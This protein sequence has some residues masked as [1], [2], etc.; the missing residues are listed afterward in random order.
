[1]KFLY[2]IQGEAELV[3]RYYHLQD[4]VHSRA[5]YLTYDKEL[6]GALYRPNTTWAEGRN[7]LLE[8][9]LEFSNVEYFIFLDDDIEISKGNWDEFEA[10]LQKYRPAIGVPV[11]PKTQFTPIKEN[12]KTWDIQAF[13]IHD[14]QFMAVHKDVI[15]DK[16]LFPY[17]S[18][19][20]DL[21]WWAACEIQQILIHT[22]YYR[23][24]MQCNLV[25]IKNLVH[26]R[27]DTKDKSYKEKI[28]T[29]LQGQLLI[30]F[31]DIWYYWD[32]WAGAEKGFQLDELF[33]DR[34]QHKRSY[35][36]KLKDIII[37]TKLFKQK[38][39][40]IK[41]AKYRLSNYYKKR[42]FNPDGEIHSQISK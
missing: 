30:P 34:I 42:V 6:A 41:P 27:H 3:K 14:E 24:A 32:D 29:W 12:G 18:K 11:V 20:D 22:F 9:A 37:T 4:R 13:K 38:S 15:A 35:E 1:L 23:Y 40:K 36:E 5:I 33:H 28:R 25:E 31:T 17:V 2:L 19:F 26:G 7:I 10:F 39:D 8:K 21:S 16:V